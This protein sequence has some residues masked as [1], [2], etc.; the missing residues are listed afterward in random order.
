MHDA[1]CLWYTGQYIRQGS[2]PFEQFGLGIPPRF[3]IQHID[4]GITTNVIDYYE[5]CTRFAPAYT[6]PIMLIYTPLSFLSWNIASGV[7]LLMMLGAHLALGFC[8]YFYFRPLVSLRNCTVEGRNQPETR[9]FFEQLRNSHTLA[10][11]GWLLVIMSLTLTLFHARVAVR[12]GQPS[13][14]VL[15]L[16]IAALI[17]ARRKWD[18]AAG[19]ALGIALSKY[20][21]ALPLAM[22]FLIQR[23]WKVLAV[24]A[25]VQI[26]S[27]AL[28][29]ALV[30]ASPLTMIGHYIESART[31]ALKD[32]PLENGIHLASFISPDLWVWL[33]TGLIL[34]ALLLAPAFPSFKR[35]W[36]SRAFPQ[37]RLSES[38]L[39]ALL[40]GWGMLAIYHLNPDGGMIL[41]IIIPLML[42][43]LNVLDV[44]LS[45][46]ERVGLRLL[47][48]CGF[49]VTAFPEYTISIPSF[50][51]WRFE[52]FVFTLYTLA[53]T[54]VT[55]VIIRRLEQ[56][57]SAPASAPSAAPQPS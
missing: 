27:I 7:A 2:D 12:F 36:M 30:N 49:F 57:T 3:P 45:A 50:I 37:D 22:L 9:R 6:A 54:I 20:Q 4:G 43:S 55:L 39:L 33:T 26:A 48:L 28:L 42:V 51:T 23:R 31:H 52:L 47:L 10:P 53:L 34:T 14:P 11:L 8:L 18:W 32:T 44:P 35:L 17:A 16:L 41:F 56:R 15:L 19:L 24:A 5:Y 13:I 25:V 38:L 1:Y 29:S 21:V 40:M 46:A